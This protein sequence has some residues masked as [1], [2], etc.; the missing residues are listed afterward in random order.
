M[1]SHDELLAK[2]PSSPASSS[3]RS[4][5]ATR[6]A[7]TLTASLHDYDHFAGAAYAEFTLYRTFTA[8]E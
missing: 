2:W 4:L 5:A 1:I 8:T 7:D 6:F 3:F